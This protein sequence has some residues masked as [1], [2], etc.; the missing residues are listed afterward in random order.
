MTPGK[1]ILDDQYINYISS[2]SE[3]ITNIT[4]IYLA[5][6]IQRKNH[7]S[8]RDLYETVMPLLRPSQ[9]FTE[10][11][12]CSIHGMKVRSRQHTVPQIFINGAHLGGNDDLMEAEKS[13]LLDSLLS[14]EKP[15]ENR[16]PTILV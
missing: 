1:Q 5:N 12:G 4:I 11:K 14:G 15:I 3:C 10:T 7:D 6:H 13:G 9:K 8:S 16:S 2:G